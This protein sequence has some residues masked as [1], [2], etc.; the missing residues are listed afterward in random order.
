MNIVELIRQETAALADRTAIVEGDR[1]ITYGV[2]LRR[3]DALRDR[4]KQL[5]VGP[6]QR[7]AFRCADGIDY[8]IGALALLA[9]DAAVVPV[10]DT[11]SGDEVVDVIERIDVHGI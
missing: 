9:C 5:G 8:V 11:N 2:L 6:G 4:L 3:I 10:P 7:I 1:T